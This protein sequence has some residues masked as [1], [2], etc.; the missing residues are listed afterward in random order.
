MRE[1]TEGVTLGRWLRATWIGWIAAIPLITLFALIGESVGIGGSQV[2][3]GA[4]IGAGIG[5]LQAL[6]LRGTLGKIA[7]WTLATILGMASPFL[8]Y[9]VARVA[10]HDLPYSL[11]AY[12]PIGGLVVGIAQ[13]ALLRRHIKWPL[14]WPVVSVVGWSLAAAPTAKADA[15][16][17]ART[18]HGWSGLAIYLGII[19]IGGGILSVVTGVALTRT[20]RR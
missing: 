14:V 19:A 6:V 4:G 12:I 5:F 15:M 1:R 3:V 20:L 18:I 17:Q 11:Y 16:F 10:G 8:V 2:L 7:P 13:A 9:D